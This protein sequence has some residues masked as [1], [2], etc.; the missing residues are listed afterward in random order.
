MPAE[1]HTAMA[2]AQRFLKIDRGLSTK[3]SL[4]VYTYYKPSIR[5]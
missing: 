2:W 3:L 5:S 4:A 1:R